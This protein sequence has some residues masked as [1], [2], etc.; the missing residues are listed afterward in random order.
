M[1]LLPL[2][3][4]LIIINYGDYGNYGNYGDYLELPLNYP[5]ITLLNHVIIDD[6]NGTHSIVTSFYENDIMFHVSTLLPHVANDR[7]QLARKRHIGNDIVAIV[8]SDD[9]NF[10]FSP[11]WI[12]S[13]FLRT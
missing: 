3:L 5:W 6:L 11:K 9:V 1:G 2:N 4:G 8:F 7:Q 12:P 13:Q 10:E